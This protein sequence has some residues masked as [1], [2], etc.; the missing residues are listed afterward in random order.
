[1]N[2]ILNKEPV[3]RVINKLKEFDNS[4]EVGIEINNVSPIRPDVHKIYTFDY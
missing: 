3:Q 1:M 4:L 2:E